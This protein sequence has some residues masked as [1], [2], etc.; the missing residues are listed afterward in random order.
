MGVLLFFLLLSRLLFPLTYPK[1][2][3]IRQ[4]PKVGGW[5]RAG[6]HGWLMICHFPT[7]SNCSQLSKWHVVEIFLKS[8]QHPQPCSFHCHRS[9]LSHS[10][11]ILSPTSSHMWLKIL[12]I[13]RFLLTADYW[14]W[15]AQGPG[16]ASPPLARVDSCL[17]QGFFLGTNTSHE[18]CRPDLLIRKILAENGDMAH[19]AGPE[20]WRSKL[21]N[22]IHLFIFTNSF[23]EAV[24]C[25]FF[26]VYS[27][28][29]TWNCC[30]CFQ[31][32]HV[33]WVHCL[34]ALALVL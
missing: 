21:K 23:S 18:P 2:G 11:S 5:K 13:S 27:T 31:S 1:G 14:R 4:K 9:I 24:P 8:S 34:W 29:N 28:E 15:L 30:L 3:E 26:G 32:P 6:G 25:H 33:T 12:P 22:L 16:S 20:E 7:W 10:P 17:G 19:G